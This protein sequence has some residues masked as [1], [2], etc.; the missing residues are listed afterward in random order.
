MWTSS[1][2]KNTLAEQFFFFSVCFNYPNISSMT[3][4]VLYIRLVLLCKRV[5]VIPAPICIG[6]RKGEG[7]D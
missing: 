7:K 4:S 3:G 6:M 5:D 2:Q 1:L